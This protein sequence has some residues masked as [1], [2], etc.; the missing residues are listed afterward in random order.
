MRSYPF[1]GYSLHEILSHAEKVQVAGISQVSLLWHLG[2]PEAHEIFQ[3][4]Q[5]LV[6]TSGNGVED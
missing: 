2:E 6:N 5:Y 4:F 1:L 3:S